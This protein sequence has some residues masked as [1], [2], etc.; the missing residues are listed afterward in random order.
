MELQWA[1]ILVFVGGVLQMLTVILI[2]VIAWM[3]KKF[4]ARLTE[5]EA[6]RVSHIQT[7]GD[8][9]NKVQSALSTLTE[10][11][12]VLTDI[13]QDIRDINKKLQ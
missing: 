4:D 8:A 9:F 1:N 10:R 5:L 13:K 12:S 11:T 2:G 6:W 7:E 3:A